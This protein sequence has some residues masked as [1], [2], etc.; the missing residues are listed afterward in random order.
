MKWCVDLFSLTTSYISTTNTGTW[1]Q[2]LWLVTFGSYI[3]VVHVQAVRCK[4]RLPSRPSPKYFPAFSLTLKTHQCV[5]S[6][7]SFPLAIS[8]HTG[9]IWGPIQ[10]WGN[11][12]RQQNLWWDWLWR[13]G[14]KEAPLE[15]KAAWAQLAYCCRTQAARLQAWGCQM[16]KMS[17]PQTPD[18]S[19]TSHVITIWSPSQPIRVIAYRESMVSKNLLSNS[20]LTLL[21]QAL[22]FSTMPLK[23]KR[24]HVSQKWRPMTVCSQRL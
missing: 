3:T 20:L 13:W 8:S 16:D 18:S 15:D 19:S 9:E 10:R 21:T 7:F 24:Q 11:L 4:R 12:L 17:Q 22:H 6:P 23:K 14:R 1:W 2:R 5:D